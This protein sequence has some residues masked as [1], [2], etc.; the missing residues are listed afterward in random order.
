VNVGTSRGRKIQSAESNM[1]I[2]AGFKK[3]TIKRPARG[4]YVVQPGS[5]MQL[6][7]DLIRKTDGVK[8]AWSRDGTY[9]IGGRSYRER[10]AVL[11]LV[12][13]RGFSETDA[14]L[15]LKSAKEAPGRSVEWRVVYPAWVKEA[16]SMLSAHQPG[17]PGIPEP[18]YGVESTLSRDLPSLPA[19]WQTQTV[20]D[21]E[22]R[23]D[24]QRG[25]DLRSPDQNVLNAVTDAAQTGR[26][27]VFDTSAV[28]SLLQTTQGDLQ[29]D[30]WLGPLM[31]GLNAKGQVLLQLYWHPDDFRERYGEDD[32]SHLEDM[33]RNTFINDGKLILN[34]KQQGVEDPLDSRR[35]LDLET[36][37]EQ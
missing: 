1:Y 18:W 27:E 2:P 34:L 24:A 37:S 14:G 30:R 3:L 19:Q 33:L 20:P 4:E 7:L 26:K 28:G 5:P 22:P 9:A 21:L 16:D 36:A 15:L 23:Q 32:I 13:R 25:Y 10:D 12:M 29:V 35:E 11:H 6:T 8:A 31:Q 17:A